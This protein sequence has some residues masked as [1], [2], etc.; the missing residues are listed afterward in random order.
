MTASP[1][2]SD[3]ASLL[4]GVGLGALW[5]LLPGAG[6]ATLVE[7]CGPDFGRGWPR[8]GWS[9][10]LA[11]T[12]LPAVDA[13]LVRAGGIGMMLPL[14]AGL[15]ILA[16]R[17]PDILRPQR[18]GWR[19]AVPMVL[20]WFILIVIQFADY[21]TSDGMLN[22]SLL[23]FDLVKHAAV[24]SA[25]AHQGVPFADP[26]FARPGFAGYYYYFYLLPAAIHWAGEPFVS[27]RMA[28]AAAAFWTGIAVPA[29]LWQISSEAGLITAERGRRFMRLTLLFCFVSGTDLLW[30]GYRY[31]WSGNLE[32]R[33]DWWSTEVTFVLHSI[34]W[35]PHHIVALI[36]AWI[37]MLLL[38]QARQL[39]K[40]G[41][42][43]IAVLAGLGIATCFGSSVWIMLT[44]APVLAGWGL[45]SLRKGDITILIA[46]MVA[47]LA[48]IYQIHD[49]IVARHDNALPI[50]LTIRP[51]T[52]ILPREGSWALLHL[53]ALPLNYAME[54][55][56]FAWGSILYRHTRKEWPRQPVQILLLASAM[57]SLL[58]ASFL[59]ST[60]INNDLGWRSI[61]FAQLAA[62]IWTTASLH[63]QP[64]PIADR[65]FTFKLLLALGIAAVLW[66]IAGV[67]L[68]RPPYAP[69]SPSHE[70]FRLRSDNLD[71]RRIY[72]WAARH[73][74]ANAV[75]QHNPALF[76]RSF[77]FGLY[78][79]QPTGVADKEANLFGASMDDV[80]LRIATIAPIFSRA[81][82]QAEIRRRAEASGVDY[83]M[84][85]AVDPV[86]SAHKGPPPG[87]RCIHREPLACLI[88]TKDI[89][90]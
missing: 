9:L 14:H 18:Q 11:L 44:I 71:Q 54:F 29:L 7:R 49:L 86:W 73:L 1:F 41:R 28:F 35:V 50:A 76:Q 83:L 39:P 68:I 88:A 66:D 16:L 19:L 43:M 40:I 48:A 84:I 52:F 53:L 25:I 26:F 46:G 15:A 4:A 62:I 23:E 59:K 67:R 64:R 2:L 27:A 63:D 21:V 36:A 38:V 58:I 60:I 89:A 32:S 17:R 6:L 70:L 30:M 57:V 12:L 65:P 37:S 74:P 78:G 13:L 3:L 20:L 81:L 51:F 87:L 22:Q 5:L 31:L 72:E 61:W 75:I 80:S 8:L 24:T 42:Y 55:G 10:S 47:L 90:R 45:I 34:V 56:I 33:S 69:T 77:N 82:P 79:R 85:A